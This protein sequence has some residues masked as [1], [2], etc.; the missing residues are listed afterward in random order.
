MRVVDEGTIL[1]EA[2]RVARSARRTLDLASPWIRGTALRLVLRAAAHGVAVRVLFRVKEPDDLEITDLGAVLEASRRGVEVRYSARLHAKVILADGSTA[3][4]SSSNLTDAAGFGRSYAP[5]TRNRELGFIVDE[6][7]DAVR[8]VQ[9]R[10]DAV[11]AESEWLDEDVTGVVMDFPTAQ[12]FHIACWRTP[13]PGGYV[14]A[15]DTQGRLVVGR[16]SGVTGYNR[17]FPRMTAGMWATQGYGA[18]PDAGASSYEYADLQSLFSV[19]EKERGVLGVIAACDP[20]GL[21]HVAKVEALATLDS[22]ESFPPLEPAA[23]GGLARCAGSGDLGPLLGAGD[24]EI[25][26]VW[27]HPDVAVLARSG[28]ILHRHLAVLGMT[29]SGKS[30]AVLVLVRA[31]LERSPDVR[32]LLVDGHGEYAQA[33]EQLCGRAVRPSLRTDILGEG[34][35]KRLLHLAREDAT[36]VA[37]VHEAAESASEAWPDGFAD[38]LEH[39]AG[40]DDAVWVRSARRLADLCRERAGE[41]CAGGPTVRFDREWG[42]GLNVLDASG[43][44]GLEARSVV[45]AAALDEVY[46]S[47]VRGEGEWLVALDEA[48]NYVPEQ[49]TGLLARVR[50]SFEAAFRIA[51]EGRKFGVGLVVASQRP[52]RVHKDVLSQCN[53]H[54]VFRL[55]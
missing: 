34:M 22:G 50:P 27:H 52:A 29:G 3:I 2:L 6:D 5:D 43:V 53:S 10:F 26:A 24:V 4:V 44:E 36:L 28:E 42:P 11:W 18:A 23:P 31:L 21:F 45:V 9:D 35:L 7:P 12:A 55:A 16:V 39:S 25:G 51:S 37:K 17:T 49:Q 41:L 1:D 14:A 32:V 54:L 19:A 40:S 48:Q 46:W 30:N 38:A 15:R 33:A 20:D 13:T 8:D 47:A